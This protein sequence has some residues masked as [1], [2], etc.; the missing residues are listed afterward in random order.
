MGSGHSLS[1]VCY[2]R[3]PSMLVELLMKAEQIGGFM[4]TAQI[5]E[6]QVLVNNKKRQFQDLYLACQHALAH[7]SFS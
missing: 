7:K 6:A 2:V 1:S 5:K 4:E 3:L